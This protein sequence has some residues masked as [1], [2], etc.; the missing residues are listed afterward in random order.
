MIHNQDSLERL[1][2]QADC[3][4]D[5]LY[6]DPPYA[7][8]SEIIIRPDGKV[9]YNKA[10]DFMSKREMPTGIWWEEWYKEAHRVLKHWWHCLMFGMDRQLLLFKYYASLAGL[11]EKQ[12]LYWYFISNF[13]KATDLSKQIDKN[14]G[15]EREVV[16]TK[17]SEGGRSGTTSGIANLPQEIDI[18]TPSTHLAKKYDWYKYSIAPLKQTNETIMVFQKPYKT[19][20]CLHDTLAYENGNESITCGALDIDGNR[21]EAVNGEIFGGGGLNSKTNGFQGNS[22]TPYEKGMGFRDDTSSGRYPSQTFCSSETAELLDAQSGVS[23]SNNNRKNKIGTPTNS[24]TSFGVANKEHEYNDTWWCSKIL[25]KCDFEKEEHDIYF[26]CPK[27]SKSERNAGCKEMEKKEAPQ[28][29]RSKPAEGRQSHIGQP[30]ANHHPTVKPIS[31]NERVLKLFKTPNPQRIIYPFAWS[32]SEIIGWIKAGFTDWEWCE[33]N[34]EY[35]DIANARIEHWSNK[36]DQ[37]D[38]I[39]EKPLF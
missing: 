34:P 35:I 36:I 31:L 29:A 13:P 22:K 23:K 14:A 17:K 20:S 24:P 30:R 21:V 38:K 26:Y 3:S 33:L 1:K 8:G 2:T 9:D 6:C 28:S 11:T 4:A 15:A 7:L 39:K 5:I 10:S 37:E 25:H 27:V 18:T 12:S 32:W 16:G 19:G